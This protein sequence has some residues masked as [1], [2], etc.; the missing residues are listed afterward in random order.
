LSDEGGASSFLAARMK[1]SVWPNQAEVAKLEQ[2][3][4]GVVWGNLQATSGNE[5]YSV[6]RSLFFY[7]PNLVPG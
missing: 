7:Q 1:Q 5:T 3:V 2:M 4:D 6:K